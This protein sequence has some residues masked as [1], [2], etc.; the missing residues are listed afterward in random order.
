LFVTSAQSV[1]FKLK[2]IT[3]RNIEELLHEMVFPLELAMVPGIA[4]TLLIIVVA[5]PHVPEE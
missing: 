2:K 5:L 3:K 4:P 1:T